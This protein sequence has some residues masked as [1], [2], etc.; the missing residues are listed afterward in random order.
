MHCYGLL[1][2]FESTCGR[3]FCVPSRCRST[4]AN[5]PSTTLGCG[6]QYSCHFMPILFKFKYNKACSTSQRSRV[7][8]GSDSG[9]KKSCS[10][11]SRCESAYVLLLPSFSVRHRSTLLPWLPSTPFLK[12]YQSLLQCG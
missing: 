3:R 9:N 8:I 6:P 4:S 10:S 11:G 12:V 1:C 7:F 5:C 2:P